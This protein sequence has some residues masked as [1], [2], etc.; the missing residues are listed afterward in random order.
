MIF[1][2]GSSNVLFCSDAC[3]LPCFVLFRFSLLGRA[4]SVFSERLSKRLRPKSSKSLFLSFADFSLIS[5]PG[6]ASPEDGEDLEARSA[7]ECGDHRGK[8]DS[9]SR[10]AIPNSFL[11]YFGHR[12]IFRLPIFGRGFCRFHFDRERS[13]QIP[14]DCYLMFCQ[15]R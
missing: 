11:Q 8:N 14:T 3:P 13:F 10:L 4:I 9:K 15:G 6:P 1:W 5:G 2:H 7:S 12:C